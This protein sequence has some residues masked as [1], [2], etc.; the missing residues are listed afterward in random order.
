MTRRLAILVAVAAYAA[1]QVANAGC[2]DDVASARM[3]GSGR[4]C[5]FGLCLYDAQLWAS[6]S[7]AAFDTPFALS[8]AYR[9]DVKGERLVATGIAEIERLAA[10]PLPAATRDAW[11]A[12]IAGAFTD[13]LRGDVLCGVYL[14]G[15]GARFYKND[16]LMSDVADP[17]F[18]RAFFAIWFDPRTRAA[19]LRREL[20]GDPV[21]Q[22][23]NM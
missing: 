4:F 12:D 21:R 1:A 6:R 15:R 13:V 9:H 16:R 11:R 23:P 22:G 8:L 7:P 10:T 2:V 20:L 18:A 5:V 17:D 3:I 14:P 19:S